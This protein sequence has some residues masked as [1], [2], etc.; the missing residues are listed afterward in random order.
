MSI[1]IICSCLICVK[2]SLFAYTDL[3]VW[4]AQYNLEKPF[5]FKEPTS[6]ILSDE[7]V[8]KSIKNSL[9]VH[10]ELPDCNVTKDREFNPTVVLEHDIKMPK[11]NIDIKKGTSF[12]YLT[13]KRMERYLIMINANDPMQVEFARYYLSNSDVVLYKGSVETFQDWSDG[14]VYIADESFQRA[15]KAQC[16]P[17]VYIQ[18]EHVFLI[19]EFNINEFTRG[20]E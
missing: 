15:F 10:I 4:G 17:S 3:G 18:K 19:R 13:I 9:K 11:F 7:K 6:P 1:K 12:N 5:E 20:Q 14:H 2:I 16:L 8:R